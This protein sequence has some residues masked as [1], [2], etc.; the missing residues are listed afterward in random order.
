MRK[1]RVRKLLR[2]ECFQELE[3]WESTVEAMATLRHRGHSPVTEPVLTSAHFLWLGAT[4]QISSWSLPSDLEPGDQSCFALIPHTAYQKMVDSGSCCSC[5]YKVTEPDFFWFQNLSHGT[6]G[7][8]LELSIS[9]TEEW[10]LLG[11][12]AVVQW[13]NDPA[14]PCEGAGLIPSSEG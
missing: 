4:E 3:F 12:P 10:F 14:F 11:V 8:A 6:M 7:A 9:C 13:V 1:L 2:E 5:S